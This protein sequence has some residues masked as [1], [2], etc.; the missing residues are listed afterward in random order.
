[1]SLDPIDPRQGF[2]PCRDIVELNNP[3]CEWDDGPL[4]AMF[5][6]QES[7]REWSIQF[8]FESTTSDCV[9]PQVR[10]LDGQGFTFSD[11]ANEY[12]D[13]EPDPPAGSG[14]NGGGYIS[15]WVRRDREGNYLREVA[16]DIAMTEKPRP[17]ER[18][19]VT[20]GARRDGFVGLGY[21]TI[22][23]FDNTAGP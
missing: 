5:P 23:D 7:V 16:A 13:M 4:E 12:G 22:L 11:I 21:D 8:W 20:I 10:L 19:L 2:L 6:D 18:H 1:M 9:Q 17:G 3:L 15:H 14:C